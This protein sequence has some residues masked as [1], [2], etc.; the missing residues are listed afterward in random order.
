[1]RIVFDNIIFFLQNTG[2]ISNYWYQMLIR[3]DDNSD[4]KFY[5]RNNS[6]NIFYKLLE[7]KFNTF[8]TTNFNY[9]LLIDRFLN[10]K[11]N[12]FNS[13]EKFIFHSSYYRINKNKYAINIITV[14][15]F[16]HEKFYSGI[17]RYISLIQKR[18]AIYKA[19][20]IITVSNSTK[21]DLLEIYPDINPNIIKVVYN[22]VSD[23][24][25]QISGIKYNDDTLLYL[26]AREE[27]KNFHSI[28][29]ILSN[30]VDYKLVIVG[31]QL[32]KL[33]TNFLN[34]YLKNRWSFFTKVPEQKL[35]ELYNSSFA[36]VY[37][38]KYEGFGIPLLEAMK[39]GCPFIALNNSSIPEVAG[40]AGILIN[41]LTEE[42]VLKA[43]KF[44]KLNRISIQKK[45]FIQ[46]NKFSWENCFFQ[47]YNLYSE[48][49]NNEN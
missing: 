40:D 23:N 21:K 19:D 15:D 17:R 6:K 37:P 34:R 47:T 7:S 9:P 22:G 4:I 20:L 33:E 46:S 10:L 36:L 38:S 16:I 30:L 26:G 13:N 2:G 41:E 45:G 43:L 49:I 3:F 48:M 31:P 35:N 14:H 44:I 32:S 39:S 8:N 1:M 11:L 12:L 18:K 28:V 25:F 5:S 27:Y 24:Y 42:E 29:K